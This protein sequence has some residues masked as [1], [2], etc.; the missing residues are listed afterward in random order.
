MAQSPSNFSEIV[1]NAGLSKQAASNHL[2]SL[3]E[4]E[5]I[6]KEGLFFTTPFGETVLKKS[7]SFEFIG[8]NHLYFR[9]HFVGETPKKLLSSIG[10]LHDSEFVDGT[11]ANFERWK[12]M[13]NESELFFYAILSQ[14]PHR[15]AEPLKKRIENDIEVK[16]IFDKGGNFEDYSEFVR[17]FHLDKTVPS[18]KLERRMIGTTMLNVMITEKEA[19]L[20]FPSRKKSTDFGRMF[21]SRGKEFRQWCMDFFFYRWKDAVPFTRYRKLE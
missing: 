9:D 15:L 17:E 14:S 19:C 8:K 18:E 4:A 10:M 7:S 12:R 5:L 3:I 6:K 21:I 1:K 2:N 20:M 11:V 13:A 16:F